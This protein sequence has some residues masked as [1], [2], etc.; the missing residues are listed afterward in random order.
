MDAVKLGSGFRHVAWLRNLCA[1]KLA[2]LCFVMPSA[3]CSSLE[4]QETVAPVQESLSRV[5][6]T[7]MLV[8]LSVCVML[9]V[10]LV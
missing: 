2:A 9:F 3:N 6:S 8:C 4:T 10:D 7:S 5:T 1:S